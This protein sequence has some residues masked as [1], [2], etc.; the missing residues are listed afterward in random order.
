MTTHLLQKTVTQEQT[1]EGDARGKVCGEGCGM[2]TLPDEFTVPTL[3]HVHQPEAPW[4]RSFGVFMKALW[5][6]HN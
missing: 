1:E 2:P 5:H 3:T 6:W 4:T